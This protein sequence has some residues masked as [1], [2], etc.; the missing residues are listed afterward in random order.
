MQTTDLIPVGSVEKLAD[1][2]FLLVSLPGAAVRRV[3]ATFDAGYRFFR[4]S[5]GQKSAVKLPDDCGYRP[6][7]VEYSQSPERPDPFESFTASVRTVGASE[8]LKWVIA[9]VLY[10]R[11]L[12]TIDMLE[13]IA[14]ALTMQL[15]DSLSGRSSGDRLRGALR[16]WSCL[17]VN[18]SRPSDVT[19]PF[20]HEAHEDGHLMTVACSDGPGLEIQLVDGRFIPISTAIGKMLIMPGDIAWMLSGG[21]IRRLYHRVRPDGRCVERM[22]LL[23]FCD[24][25]PRLC[26]PWVYNAVNAGIDIGARVLTNAT[27]FGL[28][29]F[30]VD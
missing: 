15:A 24:I 23:L 29:G 4:A 22:A 12:A 7:G 8:R 30:S 28:R 6:V 25:D 19:S 14:E 21:R 17:Q 3:T 27:R 2:G 10:Q 16:R 11:M 9:R 13:P 26:E 18:Y 20:I 1:D 5:L